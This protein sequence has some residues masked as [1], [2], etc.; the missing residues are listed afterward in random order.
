MTSVTERLS[1]ISIRHTARQF[2]DSAIRLDAGNGSLL[3]IARGGI[4]GTEALPATLQRVDQQ[5][6]KDLRVLRAH[7]DPRV[8]SAFLLSEFKQELGSIMPNLEEIGI[9]SFLLSMS[10]SR[11]KLSFFATSHG[12]GC[13][14]H[15][16]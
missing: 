3:E 1:N 14:S 8:N 13:A 2:C 16:F 11:G 12:T 7:V 4:T 6:G 15:A 9:T 10:S 5:V